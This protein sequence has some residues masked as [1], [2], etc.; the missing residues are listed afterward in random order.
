[1]FTSCDVFNITKI[2]MLCPAVLLHS[3]DEDEDED[4]Y[5]VGVSDDYYVGC[6]DD[7]SAV[8]GS[9]GLAG[10]LALPTPRAASAA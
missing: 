2:L 5:D 9:P 3:D 4:D 7:S 1:M 10:A 6:N 8:A